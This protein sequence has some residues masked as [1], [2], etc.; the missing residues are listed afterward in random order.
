MKKLRVMLMVAI[1]S[2]SFM[3]YG[4][5]K[6]E[7]SVQ[8]QEVQEK[9]GKKK[10]PVQEEKKEEKDETVV[11]EESKNEP[12]AETVTNMK[13]YYMDPDIGEIV[14]KEIEIDNVTPEKIWEQFKKEG[15]IKEE[16]GLNSFSFNDVDKKIDIDVN[17][18]FG[19]YIRSMGTAGEDILITCI[20]RS[21]LETYGYEGI[22]ITE[23]GK[24]LET[25][26]AVLDG[27]MELE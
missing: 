22:R 24:V 2:M 13:I 5:E 7:K 11:E 23:D 15:V 12:V 17:E 19:S 27:Y 21:Y 18:A 10:E 6:E 26:H 20:T 4:C 1:I 3:M 9:G 16:C 8:E 25:G 14:S